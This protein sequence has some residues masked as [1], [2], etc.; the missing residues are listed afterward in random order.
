MEYND[1]NC[2]LIRRKWGEDQRKVQEGKEKYMRWKA[3]ATAFMFALCFLSG[4]GSTA[5]DYQSYIQG[6]YDVIYKGK[7]EDYMS[8]TDA[9]EEESRKQYQLSVD[10]YVG[11]I[12]EKFGLELSE[13]ETTDL[14]TIVKEV[15]QKV[16][17]QVEPARK[18]NDTYYVDVKVEPMDYIDIT[19]EKSEKLKA[20]LEAK[21]KRGEFQS[22]EDYRKEYKDGIFTILKESLEEVSYS[23]EEIFS[24]PIKVDK[25]TYHAEPDDLLEATDYVFMIS[26]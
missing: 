11:M 15:L 13:E 12:S 19:V 10:H 1:I 4:C 25:N 21:M 17:Y 9:T 6:S 7:F 2:P 26:K 24:I 23:E 20:E 16:K 5:S 18:K 8:T 22:E 3:V 14:E